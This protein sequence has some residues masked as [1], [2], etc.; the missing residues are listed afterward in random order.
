MIDRMSSPAIGIGRVAITISL[1]SA[2]STEAA[3]N[4]RAPFALADPGQVHALLT[5]AEFQDV[6][7]RTLIATARFPSPED[8]VA[9]QLAA[10]PLSTLGALTAQ[11][12]E[13]VVRDVET[14][15]GAYRSDDGLAVPMEAHHALGHT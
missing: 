9:A 14:A 6:Q 10:T 12:R 3:N 8:L 11:T 13:A 1:A 5:A 7:V 4:R 15:L 2:A